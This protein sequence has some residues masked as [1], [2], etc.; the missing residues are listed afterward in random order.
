[1][2]PHGQITDH[3]LQNLKPSDVKTKNT[4]E[5]TISRSEIMIPVLKLSR[6]LGS[7]LARSVALYIIWL[8]VGTWLLM[9]ISCRFTKVQPE[10]S[11]LDVTDA[12]L[13]CK[14]C[15]K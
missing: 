6:V 7:G 4:A 9:S 2:G 5:S 3:L 12:E 1:M 11:V 15:L 13:A 8:K 14:L 10:T